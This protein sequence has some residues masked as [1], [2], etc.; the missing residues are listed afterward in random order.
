MVTTFTFSLDFEET[1]TLQPLGSEILRFKVKNREG[2]SEVKDKKK[3][4]AI[5]KIPWIASVAF[6]SLA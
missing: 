5:F 4:G 6:A 3:T 1:R 2:L